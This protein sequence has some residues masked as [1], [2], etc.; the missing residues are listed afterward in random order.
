MQIFV[1]QATAGCTLVFTCTEKTTLEE[2]LQWVEDKTALPEAY[3]YITYNGRYV[4][5]L[6]DEQKKCTFSELGIKKEST[7]TLNGRLSVKP[8]PQKLNAAA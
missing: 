2:F 3:Y 4:H 7:I 5:K 6:T 8:G 1:K